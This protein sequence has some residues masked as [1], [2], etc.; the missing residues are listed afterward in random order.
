MTSVTCC[1]VVTSPTLLINEVFR[2]GLILTSHEH[3]TRDYQGER[4]IPHIGPLTKVIRLKLFLD[5]VPS[6]SKDITLAMRGQ[7][8]RL[9]RAS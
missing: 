9:S 5:I 7:P 4:V 1:V 3:K 2:A 8:K 6:S